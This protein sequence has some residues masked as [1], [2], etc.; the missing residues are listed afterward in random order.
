[1]R[2]GDLSAE[3]LSIVHAL[4]ARQTAGIAIAVAANLLIACSL[5]MQKWVHKTID[6]RTPAPGACRGDV[7]AA[8][9]VAVTG[10]A[11][12]DRDSLTFR[13]PFFWVALLGL[14]VGEIGNVRPCW[15]A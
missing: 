14:I 8:M 10:K 9:T 13:H 12:E 15:H 11:K 2:Y 4:G 7:E 1:M 6:G 3:T 5:V